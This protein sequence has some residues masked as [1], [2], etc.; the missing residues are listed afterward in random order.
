MVPH[1]KC[2]HLPPS[3]SPTTQ[4]VSW[5]APWQESLPLASPGS[6]WRA[7]PCPPTPASLPP[8]PTGRSSST[9]F[10]QRGGGRTSTTRWS[11]VRPLMCTGPWCQ[12]LFISKEVWSLLIRTIQLGASHTI[13]P[14]SILSDLPYSK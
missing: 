6:P 14:F 5:T 9:S 11:G 13:T 3:H 4:G 12:Q 7:C 8:S 2:P 1:L 10:P